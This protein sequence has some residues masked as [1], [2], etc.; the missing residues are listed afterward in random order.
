MT[1][2]LS[3]AETA[4]LIRVQLKAKFPG[5]KFSV[6]SNV[7]SGGASIDIGWIDGPTDKM[8]DEV[9]QP[10]AGG[11]FDGMID[12]AYSKTAFLLPDGSATFAQTSGTAGS[13]GTVEADKAFMPVAGAVRVHF[14]ANYVFTRRD[15]SRGF[16]ERALVS[17]RAKWGDL[18]NGIEI[19]DGFQPGTANAK[20]SLPF[21]EDRWWYDALNKR[22]GADLIAKAA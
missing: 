9:V 19:V 13:G 1:K 11:G 10:F 18:A 14:G 17:Y 5:I 22:V 6:K 15:N 3:C 20:L 7:Y 4:K 2:Y 21:G 16:L 8:V 12:M